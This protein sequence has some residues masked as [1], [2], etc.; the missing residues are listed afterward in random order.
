MAGKALHSLGNAREVF[1]DTSYF[2]ALLNIRDPHH[3]RAVRISDELATRGLEVYVTWEIVVE[4][5]TL[6]RYR[7]SFELAR[8]FLTKGL[9]EIT[10]LYAYEA[11]RELATKVFLQRGREQ[12]LSLCDA[13]SYVVVSTRLHWVPCLSFDTDFT[14]LGLTIVR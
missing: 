11:E 10:V 14:A 4:T 1:A 3:G 9:P 13:L 7:A 5:V 12:E 2:F 8:I 6:L